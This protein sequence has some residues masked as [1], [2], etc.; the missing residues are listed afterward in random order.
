MVGTGAA[1]GH[2]GDVAINQQ[3][4]QANRHRIRHT[5]SHTHRMMLSG[6]ALI[7][8]ILTADLHKICYR[9]MLAFPLAMYRAHT[10]PD[11][12][13]VGLVNLQARTAFLVGAWPLYV[14][15]D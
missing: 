8:S 10:H 14:L 15:L 2:A 11:S 3:S 4:Q 1:G 7:D 9:R 12:L 6:P 13:L 5:H